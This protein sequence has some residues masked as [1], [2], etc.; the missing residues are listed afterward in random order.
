MEIP[1]DFQRDAHV[2]SIG[3]LW[4]LYGILYD[5]SDFYGISMGFQMDFYGIHMGISMGFLWDSFGIP[6]RFP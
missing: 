2:I 4:D 5:I 6:M 3:F 1:L